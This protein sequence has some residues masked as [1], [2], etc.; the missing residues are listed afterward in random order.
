MRGAKIFH[1][2]KSADDAQLGGAIC[3]EVPMNAA[4]TNK[5]TSINGHGNS[6]ATRPPVPAQ[7]SE[8]DRGEYGGV[9]DLFFRESIEGQKKST[10]FEKGKQTQ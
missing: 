1:F 10:F 8:W 7:Y 9:S 6:K 3:V 5:M 2:I 4:M